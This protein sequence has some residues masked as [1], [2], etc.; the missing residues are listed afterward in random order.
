MAANRPLNRTVVVGAR[1]FRGGF[2]NERTYSFTTP[3][4]LEYTG[5]APWIY[6]FDEEMTRVEEEPSDN[7]VRGFVQARVVKEVIDK[8]SHSKLVFPGGDVYVVPNTVIKEGV[9]IPQLPESYAR[10]PV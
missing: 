5:T 7:G 2:A 9:E 4:G 6:C 10:V 3:D 1:I 8:P